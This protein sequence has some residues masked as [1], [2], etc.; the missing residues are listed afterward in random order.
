MMQNTVWSLRLQGVPGRTDLGSRRHPDGA[1]TSYSISSPCARRE[2][3]SHAAFRGRVS[4]RWC[5]SAAASPSLGRTRTW[6]V[7]GRADA[8]TSWDL[9]SKSY[10]R[11]LDGAPLLRWW[12]DG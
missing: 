10:D 3:L 1:H 2:C 12:A 4:Y 6:R 9:P 5:R 11:A 7:A 8:H